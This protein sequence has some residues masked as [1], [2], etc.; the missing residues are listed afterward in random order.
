MQSGLKSYTELDGFPNGGS[1]MI[2]Q[3]GIRPGSFYTPLKIQSPP[4]DPPAR[5]EMGYGFYGRQLREAPTV[6]LEAVQILLA[7]VPLTLTG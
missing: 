3:V 2:L 5:G 4:A 6:I 1:E 7:T